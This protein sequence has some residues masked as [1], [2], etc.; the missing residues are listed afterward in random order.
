M[1]EAVLV[2]FTL[3]S[4]K[5]PPIIEPTNYESVLKAILQELK[6]HVNPD[7]QRVAVISPKKP[8]Y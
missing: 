8:K 1:C 2:N 5:Q 4:F 7:L 6:E 3:D